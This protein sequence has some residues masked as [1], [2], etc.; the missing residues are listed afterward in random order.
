LR[1]QFRMPVPADAAAAVIAEAEETVR[2][3]AGRE[4]K[5][6]RRAARGTRARRRRQ[7]EAE[8]K[9]EQRRD[10]RRSEEE[11]LRVAAEKTREALL[12]QVSALREASGGSILDCFAIL[13]DPRGRRG[14]RYSLPCVLALTVTA[15]LHGKTRLADITAWIGHAGQDAL[16]ALGARTGPDGKRAAPCGRTV[17][18][19]LALVS[20]RA[21]SRAVAAWLAAAEQSGPVTF[22]LAAPALL[23]H[24]ACDG[25][26]VRGAVRPDGSCL[27]LLSAA[28]AGTGRPVVLADREI[29]A[30]TNEIPELG[31]MLLELSERFP[32]AG[33]VISADALHTQRALAILVTEK[34]QAHYLLTVKGNQPGLHDALAALCWA[35]ARQRVTSGKGHGR[36]ER[37]SHLIMDA[38]GEIRN[39]F[40]HVRQV[41]KVIRTRTV[42]TWKN[43][44]K[45][46][47][48]VT[49]TST[50]TV[51]LITSLT[52]REAA[53][54]HIAAYARQHWSIENQVHLIRDVTLREDA[55]KVHADNRARNLAT[56]RNAEMG[57]IRQ[58][59]RT[60]IAATIRE[61]EYDKDLIH[62]LLRLEPAL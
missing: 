42:T 16:A 56:L 8:R 39:L 41:A 7:A 55:S 44:G 49:K 52:A 32:L 33:H 51:Y 26:E 24:V 1:D 62:A 30:K 3:A 17:T 38:P 35:G 2:R 43:N 10:R 59:G 34:L 15:M 14:R 46:R 25:K 18:R 45:K 36:R 61:A 19:L 54:E 6:L 13:A 53:P 29:E 22:P 31:P 58:H 40:P 48:R 20:P 37:R 11:R 27:F 57:L 9:E 60:G 21:L 47:T 28:T 50:E 4:E 12:A 5:R 23:P